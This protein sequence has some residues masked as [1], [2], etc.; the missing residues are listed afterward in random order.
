MKI[1]VQ[2][3]AGVSA[4]HRDAQTGNKFGQGTM[5]AL[6]NRSLQPQVGFF[7]K[8]LCLYNFIVVLRQVIQVA[9]VVDPAVANEFLQ[10]SR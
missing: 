4:Y 6:F 10:R 5:T 9:K 3:P 8:A 7:P 2:I 1:P